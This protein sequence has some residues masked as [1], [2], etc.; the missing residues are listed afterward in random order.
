MTDLRLGEAIRKRPVDEVAADI[1]ATMRRAQ[2]KLAGR[3]S[4]IAAQTVGADPEAGRAVVAGFERRFPL[5]VA[6]DGRD[7]HGSASDWQRRG[8]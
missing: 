6:D 1:L 2:A 3:M 5:E 8:R 7:E 4:E